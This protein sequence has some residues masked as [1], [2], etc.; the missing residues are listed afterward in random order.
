MP[1][2]AV[3]LPAAGSSRRFRGFTQKKPFVSLAD[4]PI[5]SRT[6]RAFTDRTDVVQVLLVLA[7]SDRPHFIDQFGE[8]DDRVELVSGG[9]SRA[10][11]VYNALQQVPAS[12]EYVAV[13]DAAR[14][15]ISQPVIDRVFA[16]AVQSG[17]ATPGIPVTSTV[18][19]I[20]S[21]GQIESTID[22]SQLRLAQTPQTFAH[23][24]LLD[25][26]AKASGHLQDFTDEASL[27]EA[28]GH[29]VT[30]TEGSWDNIKIT[31]A[32]DFQLAQT[33]LKERSR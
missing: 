29:P 23:Q 26:Y 9:N 20:D 33:I 2:F 24:V 32:E 1:E 13:H 18:K 15:L 16:A 10:E 4:E 28:T 22:R 19:Q 14:P 17:A 12:V 25:A 3:I 31:T 7:D 30:V 11:S 8:C 27:V 21:A 6:V 5:W